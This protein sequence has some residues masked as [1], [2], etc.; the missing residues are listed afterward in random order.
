[1]GGGTAEADAGA[2]AEG[3]DAGPPGR[4]PRSVLI[5]NFNKDFWSEAQFTKVVRK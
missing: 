3:R 1:M 5:L 4:F 2:D